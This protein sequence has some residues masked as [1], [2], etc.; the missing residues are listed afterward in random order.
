M[1]LGTFIAS[2]KFDIFVFI[3]ANVKNYCYNNFQRN[4][5]KATFLRQEII[6][7]QYTICQLKSNPPRINVK[8]I[9]T[10]LKFD[11]RS[12]QNR[13]YLLNSI[14]FLELSIVSIGSICDKKTIFIKIA[15][16]TTH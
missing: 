10:K 2:L 13:V 3:L 11:T 15:K 5:K 12:Q 16:N 7:L 14:L 6:S 4:C 8:L 9:N 1:V